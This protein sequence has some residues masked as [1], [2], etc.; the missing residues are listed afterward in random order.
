MKYWKIIL[1]ILINYYKQIFGFAEYNESL[2]FY[3]QNNKKEI[4]NKSGM[5]LLERMESYGIPLDRIT[6]NSETQS[7]KSI[8]NNKT[9]SAKENDYDEAK[10]YDY[11]PLSF[12]RFNYTT[13]LKENLICPIP[14]P[15][16][17][18]Y[19]IPLNKMNEVKEYLNI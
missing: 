16:I 9:N 18:F 8:K 1:N 3:C 11:E 17:I 14:M 7:S 5:T 19:L 15:N 2:I 12:E 13:N 6:F 4:F 10:N